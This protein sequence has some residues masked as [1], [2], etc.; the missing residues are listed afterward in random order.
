MQAT[1]ILHNN[2]PSHL[3]ILGDQRISPPYSEFLRGLILNS[4]G[5]SP[6]MVVDLE[7]RA[8]NGVGKEYRRMV[9]ITSETFRL[10]SSFPISPATASFSAA[11]R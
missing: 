11:S 4:Y 9:L 5:S 10:F 3:A 8:L 2:L 6:P 1:F 7:A